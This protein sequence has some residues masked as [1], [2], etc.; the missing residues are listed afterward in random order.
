MVG[1]V[2]TLGING[3]EAKVVHC[4]CLVTGGLPAF[5]VVGLPD[6]AVKEAR[7]RVRGAAKS[8]GFKFPTSRIAVNLSPANLKKS[9]SHYDLPIL[10]GLLQGDGLPGEA[11]QLRGVT[12]KA[13]DHHIG[14]AELAAFQEMLF[15]GTM[16][17]E[18]IVG[19]L[20]AV[21]FR[22]DLDGA[23]VHMEQ[24]TEI[25]GIGNRM[26]LPGELEIVDIRDAMHPQRG[27]KRLQFEFHTV[28]ILSFF[29]EYTIENRVCNHNFVEKFHRR[30]NVQKDRKILQI[31]SL[32]NCYN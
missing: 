28:P 14:T 22:G 7:E 16:D 25:V 26:I 3:I 17:Q 12:L 31:Q 9:G 8:S 20:A 27:G 10:V 32:G 21:V 5:E 15:V 11:L 30:R 2:K 4:E 24:L 23:F 18:L 13:D 6:A 19:E 1:S 29:F